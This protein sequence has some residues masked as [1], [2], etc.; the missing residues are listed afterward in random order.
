VQRK[1][2]KNQWT[3]LFFLL[4]LI[5][6]AFHTS[7]AQEPDYFPIICHIPPAPDD[8]ALF[9]QIKRCRF[10]AVLTSANQTNRDSA[11]FYGLRI[12]ETRGGYSPRFP[13]RYWAEHGSYQIYQ[14]EYDPDTLGVS[15]YCFEHHT[16]APIEDV[17]AQGGLVWYAHP[18]I[19]SAGILLHGPKRRQ[20]PHYRLWELAS[21]KDKPWFILRMKIS[22]PPPD[23]SAL[24]ARLRAF[25][26][27]EYAPP[28]DTLTILD[29]RPIQVRHFQGDV[30]VYKE[31]RFPADTIYQG[32]RGEPVEFVLEWPGEVE[33]YVDWIKVATQGGIDLIDNHLYDSDIYSQGVRQARDPLIAG[34]FGSND[35]PP[36]RY[37]A[38]AYIDSLLAN[39]VGTP[40][41][42]IAS[43]GAGRLEY[44]R[45]PFY[46]SLTPRIFPLMNYPFS[47]LVPYS[48]DQFQAALDRYVYYKRVAQSYM[49]GRPMDRWDKVQLHKAAHFHLR[50]PTGPEIWVQ[51]YLSLAYGAKGILYYC[52]RT[53]DDGK[54]LEYGLVDAN[55]D[56]AAAGYGGKWSWTRRVNERL[57]ILGPIL[58]KLDWQKA[59]PSDSIAY[60]DTYITALSGA[61]YIE[62]GLFKDTTASEPV[63]YFMLVNRHCNLTKDQP[64]PPRTVVLTIRKEPNTPY[65][66]K[67]VVSGE[68]TLVRA[69]EVGDDGRFT[70][71]VT[72]GP[73]EGKLIMLRRGD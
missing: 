27:F 52:Y 51:V 19:H 55:Y 68:E 16:G 14:A 56:T 1:V 10:N 64:A 20:I 26:N 40:K 43:L 6:G 33:L 21:L 36:E 47:D 32:G 11:A 57:E 60:Y 25:V 23:S 31:I 39:E 72:L 18:D 42:L 17:D 28:F 34:W 50:H 66:L 9:W 58:K 29:W 7:W 59:F 3:P 15:Y 63:D 5:F 35:L 62:I 71:E 61:D 4:G 53:F 46:T 70:Y 8:A 2:L 65:L 12:F 44:D 54:G 30:D 13:I 22:N 48:G 45:F 41:P 49:Q 37:K 38:H 73:G 24:V 67:E 69:E